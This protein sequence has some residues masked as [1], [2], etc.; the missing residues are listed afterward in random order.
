MSESDVILYKGVGSPL[1][2]EKKSHR[3]FSFLRRKGEKP[4]AMKLAGGKKES[5]LSPEDYIVADVLPHDPNDRIPVIT[6]PETEIIMA[7]AEKDPGVRGKVYQLESG[8]K[9]LYRDEQERRAHYRDYY[10]GYK[11]DEGNEALPEN[12]TF[13]KAVNSKGELLAVTTVRWKGVSFI[14]RGRTAYRERTIVLR[15][16]FRDKGIATALGI[17]VLDGIFYRSEKYDGLPATEA[18]SSIYADRQAGRHDIN[19][20]YLTLLGFREHGASR[21]IRNGIEVP[22]SM[23]EETRLVQP[24]RLLLADYERARPIAVAHLRETQPEWAGRLEAVWPKLRAE[25]AEKDPTYARY[26]EQHP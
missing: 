14:K 15:P 25:L 10:R 6:Y 26:L 21:W 16:E 4:G 22:H 24:Y 5:L 8:P 19:R 1:D 11:D 23:D 2:S 13:F 9:A 12:S 7:V 3:F 20:N 18:R 17:E